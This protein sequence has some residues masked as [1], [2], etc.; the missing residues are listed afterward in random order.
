MKIA[1]RAPWFALGAVFVTAHATEPRL[2]RIA[3]PAVWHLVN[4]HAALREEAGHPIIQ[5]DARD[6]DG[7]AWLVGSDFAEG[8]LDLDLR[9]ANKLQQSFVGLALRGLDATTYDVI[10]FRPFNF[11]NTETGRRA[12]AVQYVS[13]PRFPWEKLRADFPGKYE[14]SVHPVPDPDGWFHARIV[15]ADRKI[16][17]FVDDATSPSLVVDELSD[18]RGGMLGLWVGNDSEGA[19]ANFKFTPRAK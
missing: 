5:L 1:A 7:V 6:D 8:T 10:Y 2:D 12:R 15:V 3:D 17:V 14:S 16:S 13:L 11:Q 9:G 4:R 19:F 18:R